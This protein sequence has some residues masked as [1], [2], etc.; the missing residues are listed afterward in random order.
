MT[1]I[2]KMKKEFQERFKK[3]TEFYYDARFGWMWKYKNYPPQIIGNNFQEALKTIK[4]SKAM[5]Y[6][7]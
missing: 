2:E 7:I 3:K 4:T 6:L 1:K 5:E